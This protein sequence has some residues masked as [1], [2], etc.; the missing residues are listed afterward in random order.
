M[1]KEKP[2]AFKWALP[3]KMDIPPDHL[4]LRLDFYSESTAMHVYEDGV[5]T[6]KVVSAD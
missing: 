3:Q 5:V 2:P 1:K 6:T 4:E